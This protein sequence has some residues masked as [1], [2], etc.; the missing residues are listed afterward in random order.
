M[1]PVATLVRSALDAAITD[2]EARVDGSGRPVTALDAGCGRVSQLRPFRS[3]IG[4]LVGADIHAPDEPLPHLDEFAAVDVCGAPRRLRARDIRPDPVE[5]H[6]RTLRRP[7]AALANLR[8]WLA[9]D[10]HARRH[11]GQPAPPVRRRLPRPARPR[12][13]APP[14]AGQ[15]DCRRTRTRSSAPAMSRPRSSM[16]SPM[17]GSA[18]SSSPRSDTSPGHGAAPGRRSRSAWRAT[19]SHRTHLPA[20]RRSSRSR[21]PDGLSA[22]RRRACRDR[23][24]RPRRPGYRRWL[25]R[26]LRP[27]PVGRI[28]C[29][30]RRSAAARRSGASSCSSSRT[31]RRSPS[32]CRDPADELPRAGQ[33]LPAQAAHR[34]GDPAARL[35]AAD[36]VRR[37]DDRPADRHGSHRRR[38]VLPQQPHRPAGHAGPARGAVPAPPVDAAAIL[39]R[40]PDRRDPEPPGERRRRRPVGRH[41]H[42]ELGH[43]ATWRSRSARSSRCG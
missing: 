9:P 39:H 27:R 4:R 38:P 20:G 40:D 42:G 12:P 31:G 37:T 43:V 7:S 5:L 13:T 11:D 29:R 8:Q 16:P 19:S 32:S 10:G 35:R 28:S 24:R 25:G 6:A 33:P 14:T 23:W 2:A 18:M 17:P 21:G 26:L 1:P 22:K 41:R 15:V 36:P 3:R 34:R 30:S